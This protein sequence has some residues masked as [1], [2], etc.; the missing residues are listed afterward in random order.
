M[1]IKK[2]EVMALALKELEISYFGHF[3]VIPQ[4]PYRGAFI[5][6]SVLAESPSEQRI[7]KDYFNK[8]GRAHGTTQTCQ[9]STFPRQIKSATNI[10]INN[11][12]AKEVTLLDLSKISQ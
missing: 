7:A 8:M 6:P 5:H 11:L 9:I 3:K 2:E 4:N 1:I 10:L 12:E